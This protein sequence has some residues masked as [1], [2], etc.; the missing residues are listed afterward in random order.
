MG[1]FLNSSALAHRPL[2]SERGMQSY[3]Y[4]CVQEGGL[5][6]AV[7]YQA[8]HDLRWSRQQLTVH[9]S[10]P[11][12]PPFLPFGEYYSP[13]GI[14]TIHCTCKDWIIRTGTV[15]ADTSDHRVPLSSKKF[16]QL[17]HVMAVLS[18]GGTDV[19]MTQPQFLVSDRNCC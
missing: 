12:F 1:P 8:S 4:G 14:I 10:I 5:C 2:T 18:H 3:F 6:R 9:H 13:S 19:L 17:L 7:L 11:E 15:A 16:L